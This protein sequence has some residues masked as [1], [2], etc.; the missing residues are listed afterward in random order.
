MTRLIIGGP[1]I[2]AIAST[3]EGCNC[4]TAQRPDGALVVI[5]DS[6]DPSGPTLTA[7]AAAWSALIAGI[8]SGRI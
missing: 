6:K 1:A 2:K 7:T 3:G 5:G 8:K 4:V